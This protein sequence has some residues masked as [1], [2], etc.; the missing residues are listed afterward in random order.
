MKIPKLPSSRFLLMSAAGIAT[1]GTVAGVGAVLTARAVWRGIQLADLTG[2]VVLITGASRG[3]GL[4]MAREFARLGC[5]L[6]I[7]ARNQQELNWAADELRLSGADVLAIPCDVGNREQVEEMVRQ[8]TEHFGRIDVLVNN[9]GIISVG[10]IE[11]QTIED[12]REAMDV[13]Y[14]GVVYP[15]MAVLPQMRARRSGRIA[16]I[17]SI[18]GKIAVPHLVPYCGAK[19]AAVGFSEGMSAE[20]A[21]DN[22]RVTTVVPGLMRT[23]SHVNAFFKGDNRAE[24]AWFSLGASSPLT[25]IA[26]TRAARSVVNAVRRGSREIILSLPA[27]I[28]S[29]IHGIAPGTTV[30]ALGVVNRF[31]PGT[32]NSDQSRHRGK[33]SGSAASQLLAKLGR[34]AGHALHQYPEQKPTGS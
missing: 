29:R 7:C 3:L 18:G 28:A 14:W 20:L 33:E 32:G 9:A 24:F 30:A 25:A 13:M 1:A 22:I 17:T 11:S 6:A 26:A 27:H 21:K 12:F 16:N 34:D 19:F 31:M 8:T 10:T 15:T 2:N 23:G 4:A 5:K